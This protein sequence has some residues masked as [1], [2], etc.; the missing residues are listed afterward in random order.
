MVPSS[1]HRTLSVSEDCE[2]G[3]GSVLDRC[4]VI[5]ITPSRRISTALASR[6]LRLCTFAARD[7]QVVQAP[8][9]PLL[10]PDFL[11]LYYETMVILQWPKPLHLLGTRT[12]QNQLVHGC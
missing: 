8:L 7:V 4:L 12:L 1:Q 5:N 3:S 9:L 10:I 2:I 6:L 11:Y